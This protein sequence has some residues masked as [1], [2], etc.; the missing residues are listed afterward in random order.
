MT[1]LLTKDYAA[2]AALIRQGKLVAFPT[3][4]V[5]G[6]GADVHRQ[7]SVRR[8]YE[9]KG[10]PADNPLIVHLGNLEQLDQVAADLSDEA[11]LLVE[12]FFP[13]PLTIVLQKHNAIPSAVTAGLNTVAVRMP[14][15]PLAQRFLQE[16]DRLVAAPSANRSGRPSGTT[17]Q[18]VHDDLGGSISAILQDEH[19][20]KG[21]ESTVVDCSKK[22]PTLLRPGA[23]TLEDLLEVIPQLRLSPSTE[24]VVVRSPGMRH[25]HYS[26]NTEVIAVTTPNKAIPGAKH[27]YIGLSDV[28][29]PGGFGACHIAA[30]ITNYAKMLFTF[31]RKCESA[32]IHTIFCEE[33]PP[34]GLGRA[35][36]DR[37]RRAAT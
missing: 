28:V 10:R 15:H 2:A 13:G 11:A 29:N 4:T 23:T 26:P 25:R 9:V 33:V 30:D 27:A 5:Y 8:L 21:I 7:E 20:H 31:F 16:C 32:G 34:D 18:A 6:L 22:V 37:I 3:E 1:T 17:W 35:L 19:S 12:N 24:E 14:A 36:M